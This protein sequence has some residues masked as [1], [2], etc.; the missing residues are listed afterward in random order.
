LA[1]FCSHTYNL[2]RL[3]RILVAHF[4]YF[5]SMAATVG[6]FLSTHPHGVEFTHLGTGRVG[7]RVAWT[8]FKV[9][10]NPPRFPKQAKVNA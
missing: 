10:A 1:H 3:V 8:L 6:N 2:A 9:P 4:R 5:S 7:G